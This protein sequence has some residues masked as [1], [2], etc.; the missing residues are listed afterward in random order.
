MIMAENGS[1]STRQKRFIVALLEAPTVRDAAESAQ[2]G[3]TTAWRYLRDP[4]VRAEIAQRTGSMLAQASA[5]VLA[6]MGAARDTLRQIM[7]D[8]A[9]SDAARVSAAR[10]ILDCG[11]RLFEMVSLADRVADLEDAIG[12]TNEN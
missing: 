3:E 6:D 9:A 1:L 2:V 12:A 10:A 8:R 7:G 4:R 11:L 5:G